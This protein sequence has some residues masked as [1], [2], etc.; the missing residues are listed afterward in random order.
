MAK[1]LETGKKGEEIAVRFLQE[2]GLEILATNWR[3]KRAEVD[4]I[5]RDEKM[6]VF[7]EVKTRSYDYFGKPEEFVD[8]KKMA[9]LAKAAAAY[10]KETGHEW[11]IRFDIVSILMQDGKGWTIEHLKDAFFP[12][13]EM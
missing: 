6:L 3:H 8:K 13:L 2:N 11:A 9:L 10:M 12:G 1:H 4:V 7:V 5:A